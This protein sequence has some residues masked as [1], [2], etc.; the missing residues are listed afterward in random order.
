MRPLVI[1]GGAFDPPHIGH[2]M[3]AAWARATLSSLVWVVPSFN[4]PFGKESSPFEERL[5]MCRQAFRTVGD[6][7]VSDIQ[8]RCGSGLMADLL[9]LL[10]GMGHDRLILLMGSDNWDARD[11]WERWEEICD[12][13][14]IQV[15]GR[16]GNPGPVSVSAVSSTA[17]RESMRDGSFK[18]DG[19]DLELLVPAAVLAY[20]SCSKPLRQHYGIR[21]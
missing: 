16:E 5:E 1:Y 18:V 9:R 6:V 4:H 11:R 19:T 10:K 20:I 21:R 12:L 14:D 3:T 7:V 2:V 17:I 8:K 15:V 13:A